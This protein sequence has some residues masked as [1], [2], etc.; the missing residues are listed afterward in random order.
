VAQGRVWTGQQAVRRGLVDHLGGVYR[1]LQI[2]EAL[3]T[4][5]NAAARPGSS[6]RVQTLR[7]AR[8]VLS[9]LSLLTSAAAVLL[10]S[11]R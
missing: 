9:P 8:S 2:A 6:I 10:G 11:R 5:A 3:A 4:P 7:E 1:A